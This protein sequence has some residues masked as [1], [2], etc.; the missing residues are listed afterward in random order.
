MMFHKVP[1]HFSELW[2][3]IAYM[4]PERLNTGWAV[5]PKEPHEVQQ[6]QVQG[7]HLGHHNLHYQYKLE[8]ERTEQSPAEKD[9]GGGRYF[10][11]SRSF[12]F[13]SDAL[14]SRKYLFV[15]LS[16]AHRC[17]SH[18]LFQRN[19][20]TSF[21]QMSSG[22]FSELICVQLSNSLHVLFMLSAGPFVQL[23]FHYA[24][25]SNLT[26]HI[27]AIWIIHLPVYPWCSADSGGLHFAV[28]LSQC[29]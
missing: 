12:L 16:L 13:F 28:L 4:H 17:T 27:T 9:L 7:L 8:D 5:G 15:L 19:L 6:C 24:A 3:F 1:I 14:C 29:H 20:R 10:L 26:Q 22:C 18:L 2:S 21:S 11:C 23:L 25:F